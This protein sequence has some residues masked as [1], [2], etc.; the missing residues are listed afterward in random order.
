MNFFEI[1]SLYAQLSPK[2][3]FFYFRFK[4]KC[5]KQRIKYCT[6]MEHNYAKYK[7][8]WHDSCQKKSQFSKKTGIF[9]QNLEQI[10][11]F[12]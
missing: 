8:T 5:I 4:T 6:N 3:G 2:L 12:C 10:N 1:L 7:L 11:K 9:R